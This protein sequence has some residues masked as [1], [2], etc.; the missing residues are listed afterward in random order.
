VSSPTLTNLASPTLV[1]SP[2]LSIADW[3][4]I[5]NTYQINVTTTNQV[6]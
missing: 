4:T 1:I 5:D 6:I 3:S 2:A